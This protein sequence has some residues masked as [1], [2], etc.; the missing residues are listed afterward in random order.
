MWNISL[1]ECGYPTVNGEEW[2]SFHP[3]EAGCRELWLSPDGSYLMKSERYSPG[4]LNQFCIEQMVWDRL[5]DDDRRYFT[6]VLASGHNGRFGWIITDFIDGMVDEY[7]RE[8]DPEL[9]EFV[10]FIYDYY[11][12]TDYGPRQWK[13]TWDGEFIIHDYGCS[14]SLKRTPE[15]HDTLDKLQVGV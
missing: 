12:I 5:E 3:D 1:D 7:E 14:G 13:E 2:F 10:R 6:P 15:Y 11:S 9:D 4:G 8:F